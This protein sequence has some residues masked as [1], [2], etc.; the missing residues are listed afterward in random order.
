MPDDP[1]QDQPGELEAL[2]RSRFKSPPLT[3]AEVRLVRAALN[4]ERAICGP[5]GDWSHATNDPSRADEWSGDRH[6]RADLVRWLSIDKRARG[7]VDPKGIQVFGARLDGSLDLSYATVPFP[8]RFSRCRLMAEFNFQFAEIPTVI[9]RGTWVRSIRAD[10]A[11]IRGDLDLESG[12]RADGEVRLLNARIT[13]D[14]SCQGCEIVSG[15]GVALGADRVIV[16]GSVFLRAGFRAVG[17]VRL[18]GAQIAGVLSCIGGDFKRFVGAEGSGTALDLDRAIIEGSV[19]LGRGFRA[20]GEVRLLG[21]QIGSNLE[22]D[23]GEFRNAILSAETAKEGGAAL[24][25]EGAVINGRVSLGPDFRADGAVRLLRTKIK[26]DLSCSGGKFRGE[27]SA[28]GAVVGGTL[29]WRGIVGPE[30]VN[31][32]LSGASVGTLSDDANSWPAKGR[33]HVDG[34]VYGGISTPSLDSTKSRLGWLARQERF[35]RQPYRQLAKVLRSQGNQSG[36]RQTLFEMERLRRMEEDRS[37]LA[38][39]WGNVLRVTV[40]YF[41][42]PDSAA[43]KWLAAL[44]VVG[45]LLYGGGYAIGIIMP[46]DKDAYTEFKTDRRPPDYYGNFNPFVYSFE[47][48]FQLVKLGQADRWQPDPTPQQFV[49]YVGHRPVSAAGCLRWFRLF[50]IVLGWFFT[51]MLVSGL[52]DIVR[53]E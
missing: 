47:N 42:D 11:S 17:E 38:R 26:D 7:F 12:F 32:D 23:G 20:E 9:L 22:C 27:M 8:L 44:V 25:A 6:I 31:L 34:F 24:R 30:D 4:G 49:V 14:L 53:K 45:A 21:A 18:L 33:L 1:G 51:T 10:G 50:Q 35:K 39:A 48:T 41:Y 37:S 19:F 5:S 29:F 52:A 2:A 46:A 3:E 15:S 43:L 36:A 13:G 16:G 28:S 40:G